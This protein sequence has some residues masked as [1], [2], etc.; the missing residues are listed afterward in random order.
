[1]SQ[2]NLFKKAIDTGEVADF[3]RGTGEY[4]VPSPDYE[5]HVHGANLGGHVESFVEQTRTGAQD[6]Y[7]AF[8]EF[9]K[10]LDVSK[11]DMNHLLANLSAYFALKSKNRLVG[12]DF[13]N[14]ID[15]TEASLIKNYLLL[16]KEHSI[17]DEEIEKI[18]RHARYMESN[19]NRIFT[20]ILNDVEA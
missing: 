19:G 3:F 8:I 11:E 7:D 4:F 10:G 12:T 15:S 6:F 20:E 13:L 9:L 14:D 17:L 5:G 18:H 1:M 16:L 2:V